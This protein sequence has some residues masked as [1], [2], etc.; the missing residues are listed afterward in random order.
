MKKNIL[1]LLVFTTLTSAQIKYSFN[2]F[3]EFRVK[4]DSLCNIADE[5]QRN[6]SVN[7][8]LDTLKARNKIP[9]A[10]KDSVAFLYRG[11]SAS[12]KWAG[13]FNGW[14]PNAAGYSGI[15]VGLSNV[16]MII[17]SF[18]S[19]ARLDYKIVLGSSWILDPENSFTQYSG[20]GTYNSELRMPGW[21]YPQET[22]INSNTPRGNLSF[23]QSI[24]SSNLKYLVFFKVYVPFDYDKYSNLPVIYL[25]DGHEYSDERLGSMLN[26][27]DNLIYQKKIKPVIA[28]FIDPRSESG[29]NRRGSE[30]TIN[31]QFA[32]CVSDELVPFIDKSYKTN[33]SPNARAILGTS[34]GG[35]NSAYFG[36]YRHD[37]FA[38]IGIHSPAFQANTQIYNL[39]EASN[40]LPLKIWMSTGT[41]NDTQANALKMK[42]IL[43]RKGYEYKYVEVPE[44]HSW[45]NWRALIDEPLQYFFAYDAST[46]MK[47]KNEIPDKLSLGNYPNPFNPS[48]Q[49]CFSLQTPSLVNLE[50]FNSIGQKIDTL[51][52]NK[53]FNAGN[54]TL[55]YN[56]ANQPNGI[57]FCRLTAQNQQKIHKIVILK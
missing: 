2:S 42:E 41:I 17:K 13:D 44:G 50:L 45:G 52:A 23:N 34:L 38:L 5:T 37:K 25:T 12:V 14:N 39:F 9:F 29:T 56:G 57:Y 55:N 30:Y 4:L 32:D 31:K 47:D 26:V 28:V 35:L 27:L 51:I 16:W 46:G 15:K 7:A 24:Y 18:P 21:V 48:T 53:N 11:S 6:I 20:V 19:N 49:I 1:Y 8:F 54:F 40:K 36:I 33:S 43:D 22:I 10:F 3:K